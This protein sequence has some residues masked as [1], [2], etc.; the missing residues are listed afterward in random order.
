MAQVASRTPEL[1]VLVA[2][3]R[4][5]GLL[6]ALSNPN[7]VLTVFA[8]NNAAFERFIEK[9]NTTA[10]ALLADT[11]TLQN[12]LRYHVVAGRAVDSCDVST[13]VRLTTL[14][15]GDVFVSVVLP[16]GTIT[17]A[18]RGSSADV[19]RADIRACSSVIHIIN[20]VLLPS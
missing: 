17:V 12:I 2:A 15:G 6:G 3:V 10:Q 20:N 13:S 8:P 19:L 9:R 18:G 7:A 1:S 5:A 4:A 16:P 14:Q 11:G